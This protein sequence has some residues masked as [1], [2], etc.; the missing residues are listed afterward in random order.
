MSEAAAYVHKKLDVTAY[1]GILQS[2]ECLLNGSFECAGLTCKCPTTRWTDLQLRCHA[3]NVDVMTFLGLVAGWAYTNPAGHAKIEGVTKNTLL[4][5]ALEML[6]MRSRTAIFQRERGV[7]NR[8]LFEERTTEVTFISAGPPQSPSKR[9]HEADMSDVM[10]RD[11]HL[12]Q[13]SRVRAGW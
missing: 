4:V 7:N 9:K 8:P 12:R 5:C 10:F 3:E 6:M 1:A 11:A 13:N 2:A